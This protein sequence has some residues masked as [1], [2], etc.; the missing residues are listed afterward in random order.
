M[1]AA[2]V[3]VGL[4]SDGEKENN[5]LDLIEEMK[6][7]SLL[8]KVTTLDPTTGDPWDVLAMATIDGARALGLDEVT[9]SLEPGKRADVVVVDLRGLHTTPVLHGNDFN[10]AAHLVFSSSG[11][12][13]RDVWI[14]GRRV[15]AE[16]RPITFDADA[17]RADAQAAAEE[18]FARRA[19]LT[20]G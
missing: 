10:A 13:V 15:V 18:L 20:A 17:V 1:R 19:A 12:D 14:D 9:G 16:H 8:Q 11:R 2:G 7:A 6:F 4:G 3:V 5:N